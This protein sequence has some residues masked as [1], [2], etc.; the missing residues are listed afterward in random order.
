MNRVLPLL[1]PLLLLP[2]PASA[3]EPAPPAV[4]GT[5]VVSGPL[6]VLTLWGTPRERGFAHGYLLA[7][8][9]LRGADDGLALVTKRVPGVYDAQLRPL[10]KTAFVFTAAEEEE[11]AGLLMGIAARLPAEKRTLPALG[12]E[13]DVIDV[14]ALNTFGDWYSLGCSSAAVWGA[15]SPDGKAAA[16]RNFDFIAMDI[17]AAGQHVRVSAPGPDG[18][19]GWVGVSYPGTIGVVTGMNAEGLFAAIHDVGVLP[20]MKD[21]LQPNVPRLIAMRRI[22]E[23]VGAAGGVEKAAASCRLWPTLF[24]NN[25]LVVTPEPGEGAPAG[26]LEYDSREAKEL[27]V[28]L[29]GPEEGGYVVCSNHHR[30]RGMDRCGRYDALVAGIEAA[31]DKA[32]DVP[33]LFALADRAA[34]PAAGARI[35]DRGFGTLHQAAALTGAKRL[36][37][38][39]ASDGNIRD[40]KLSEYDVAALVRAAAERGAR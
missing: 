10:M 11:M 40:A 28:T 3:A 7:E 17:A 4:T 29:R 20:E 12:R 18:A 27:G 37:L 31:G 34:V 9:I 26:V 39:F 35:A 32:F 23:Q 36:F 21:F 16:V 22:L 1:L 19:R 8:S 15:R 5:Y 14:K 25:F 33:A 13:L 30:R 38:R 2:V 24:G 6:P